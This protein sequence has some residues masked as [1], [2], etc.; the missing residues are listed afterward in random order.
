MFFSQRLAK[1]ATLSYLFGCGSRAVGVVVDPVA[2]DEDWFIEEAAKQSD[3]EV[4]L[5]SGGGIAACGV[6]LE[7]RGIKD[8]ELIHVQHSTLE[9]LAE[10]TMWADKTLVF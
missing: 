7:A 5:R 10:W 6:C 4:F 3:V 8:E 9:H 1:E 2:G